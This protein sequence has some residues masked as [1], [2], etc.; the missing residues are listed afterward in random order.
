MVNFYKEGRWERGL[1]S[2]LRKCYENNLDRVGL[3]ALSGVMV[4]EFELFCCRLDYGALFSER[5]AKACLKNN[6]NYIFTH[7]ILMF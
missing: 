7:G 6:S 1:P 5:D 2:V 3:F 4:N